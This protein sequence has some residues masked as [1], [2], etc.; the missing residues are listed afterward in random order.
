[1]SDLTDIL[2]TPGAAIEADDDF[3]A[4]NALYLDRGWGDGLPIVP[5]TAK[6]VEAMLAYCDR[7]WNEP[8][9]KIAPRYGEATPL[10][11]AANAVMAGC[12][13]EYF[14]LVMLAIEAMCEEP[15]NLYGIQATTHLCAPLVIVNGPAAREIGMNSGHNAFGPGTPSNATIGRAIRLALLNV[16]GA[17]PGSG[18]MSTFGAPSKY[19]YCVA[20]NEAE[21]PWEPL[22]VERGFPPHATTVTV[23][24]AECPHNINDHESLTAEG[25]LTT[26]AGTMAVTGSNDVY[27]AAQPVIVMGPEHAKTVADGGYSKADAKRFLQERATLP[28][29]KFSKE[30]IERRFHV[31]FKERY[32]NATEE[33]MV[34]AVQRA[35]DIIIAVIGGAGK[36][37]AYIPT[38]GATRSVTRALK[39]RDGELARSV[40]EVRKS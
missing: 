13:P 2:E 17:L 32:A 38:F 39:R 3:D 21:S 28:L 6:R 22:H 18:D 1:M 36:H 26:I 15:F 19:S 24:G 33:A 8:I 10:R 35:E 7:P 29:W 40:G 31:T 14:P 5:P 30:N 4:V 20:E 27:Y 23:V 37:S 16:G 25:I 12:R 34:P 9:A 11:L